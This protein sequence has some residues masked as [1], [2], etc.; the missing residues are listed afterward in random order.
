MVV[1]EFKLII[2]GLFV[3]QNDN[4]IDNTISGNIDA[5][6]VISRL[7]TIQHTHRTY[8]LHP[9]YKY[10]PFFFFLPNYSLIHY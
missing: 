5:L 6:K 4:N 9:S 10:I 1:I 8:I 2:N 7:S 3:I